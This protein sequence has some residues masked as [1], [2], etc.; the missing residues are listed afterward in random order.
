VSY[1][2]IDYVV[3]SLKDIFE[4]NSNLFNLTMK[5]AQTAIKNFFN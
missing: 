1:E 2:Q 5:S 3:D 4:N